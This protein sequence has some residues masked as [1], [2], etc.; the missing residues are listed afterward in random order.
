MLSICMSRTHVN[1]QFDHRH[2]NVFS[3]CFARFFSS[4]GSE[5]G[6]C[7]TQTAHHAWRGALVSPDMQRAPRCARRLE[8]KAS[9]KNAKRRAHAAAPRPVASRA[10]DD[11]RV[12]RC[13]CFAIFRECPGHCVFF[14]FLFLFF[15]YTKI[16]KKNVKNQKKSVDADQV[17]HAKSRARRG[18]GPGCSLPFFP[19]PANLVQP[20]LP[21][22]VRHERT[23]SPPPQRGQGTGTNWKEQALS[24]KSL[25][26]IRMDAA[27]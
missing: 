15:F 1:R 11:M 26:F 5:E 27:T 18:K 25:I 24:K 4:Q 16:N 22:H 12:R 17:L 3:F 20:D 21:G 13:V 7:V 23:L 14:L 9:K 10:R 8:A 6:G 2:S 19:F